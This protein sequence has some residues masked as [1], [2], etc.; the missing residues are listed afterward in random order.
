MYKFDHP[1]RDDLVL[2]RVLSAF[3]HPLRLEIVR[4]LAGEGELSCGDLTGN[5]PKSSMSHHFKI[6]QEAGVV[7][8]TVQGTVHTNSLRVED[9]EARYPGLLAV[10]VRDDRIISPA[11]AQG[12]DD[13]LQPL[14]KVEATEMS[15]A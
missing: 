4:R 12:G 6:L 11:D 1:H 8:T 13:A 3:A 2:E 9:I 10:V 7:S 5:R 15:L 14:G